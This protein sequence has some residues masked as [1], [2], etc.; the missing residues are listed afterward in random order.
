VDL[1][2]LLC[3]PHPTPHTLVFGVRFTNVGFWVPAAKS[4][5]VATQNQTGLDASHDDSPDEDLVYQI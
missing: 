5:D 4:K 2:F 3:V 1:S